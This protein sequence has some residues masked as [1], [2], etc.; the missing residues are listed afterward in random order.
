MAEQASTLQDMNAKNKYNDS[1][2][3]FGDQ[4]AD[5]RTKLFKFIADPKYCKKSFKGSLQWLTQMHIPLEDNL[6]TVEQFLFKFAKG[7][8]H[9][10]EDPIMIDKQLMVEFCEKMRADFEFLGRK[11]CEHLKFDEMMIVFSSVWPLNQVNDY[12]NIHIRLTNVVFHKIPV[13][14][15]DVCCWFYKIVGFIDNVAH[16]KH[17]VPVWYKYWVL[18]LI[19]MDVYR[20]LVVHMKTQVCNVMLTL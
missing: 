2:W 7:S 5:S 8:G 18:F 6:D 12:V 10:I 15:H 19:N 1:F 11:M 3:I 9:A 16:M 14:F 13:T 20:Q 4:L 17:G